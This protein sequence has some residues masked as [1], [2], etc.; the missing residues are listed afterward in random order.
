MVE[1]AWMVLQQV[2]HA[3]MFLGKEEISPLVFED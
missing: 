3:R 1:S 2:C